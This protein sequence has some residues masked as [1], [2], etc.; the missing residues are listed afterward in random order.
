[1]L[2]HMGEVSEATNLQSTSHKIIISD[3]FSHNDTIHTVLVCFHKAH[4]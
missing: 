2:A 3:T 1:M 4:D